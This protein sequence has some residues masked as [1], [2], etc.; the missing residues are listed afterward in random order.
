M[1]NRESH[2]NS[3][4]GYYCEGGGSFPTGKCP[5]GH[6]CLL[7]TSYKYEFPCAAGEYQP[8]F[9]QIDSSSCKTCS[10]GQFCEAG[11]TI[12]TPCPFGTY[13]AAT[14]NQAKKD[15][16]TCTAGQFCGTGTIT[17]QG[18]VYYCGR[19]FFVIYSEL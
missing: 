2:G 19:E 4:K 1:V 8:H 17:P 13:M 3:E 15:C 11:S 7:K 5:P 6:Y 10:E 14:G 18:E 9:L 16:T 12:E